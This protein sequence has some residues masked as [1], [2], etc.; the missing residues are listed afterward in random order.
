[1]LPVGDDHFLDDIVFGLVHG[2]EGVDVALEERRECAAGFAGEE[3]GFG[4]LYGLELAAGG[5]GALEAA[6]R[7]F[8]ASGSFAVGERGGDLGRGPRRLGGLLGVL[9]GGGGREDGGLMV[10]H[11]VC[12]PAPL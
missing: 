6:L 8:W 12:A 1:M 5:E 7:G 4:E 11:E 3:N 10:W 2:L 9:V